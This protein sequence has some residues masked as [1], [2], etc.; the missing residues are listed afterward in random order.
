MS[1]WTISK[2]WLYINIII[3]NRSLK[4]TCTCE[5]RKSNIWKVKK[6]F[7]SIN[8]LRAYPVSWANYFYPN[9]PVPSKSPTDPSCALPP[10]LSKLPPGTVHYISTYVGAGRLEMSSLFSN[11]QIDDPNASKRIVSHRYHIG[12][13]SH[14][15]PPISILISEVYQPCPLYV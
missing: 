12:I 7:K 14:P 2:S 6:F 10:S 3:Y 13:S 5:T 11:R 15:G 1:G 4:R 8:T 9:L